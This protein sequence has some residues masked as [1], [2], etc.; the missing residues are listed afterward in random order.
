MQKDKFK[1]VVAGTVLLCFVLIVH[2]LGYRTIPASNKEVFVH[3]IGLVEGAIITIV[4][5]YFGSS[6]S[7]AEKNE[8]INNLKSKE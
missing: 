4:S 7:S 8:I 3:T 2:A 1:Y 6:S 5:Y